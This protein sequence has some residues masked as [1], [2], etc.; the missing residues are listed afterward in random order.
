[1][2]SVKDHLCPMAGRVSSFPGLFRCRSRQPAGTPSLHAAQKKVWHGIRS[3]SEGTVQYHS[4]GDEV[5]P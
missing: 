5:E 2:G 1:M 3:K 4:N